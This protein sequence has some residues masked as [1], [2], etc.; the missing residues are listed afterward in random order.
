MHAIFIFATESR[1]NIPGNKSVWRI[2]ETL[3][4]LRL[5]S[6]K[7]H[8][9]NFKSIATGSISI[10]RRSF[11]PAS[12]AARQIKTRMYWTRSHQSELDAFTSNNVFC[13]FHTDARD[14]FSHGNRERISREINPCGAFWRH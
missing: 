10:A 5:C 11:H 13:G 2:L 3:E 9:V 7:L 8:L 12:V 4:T 1:A 14:F 6:Y